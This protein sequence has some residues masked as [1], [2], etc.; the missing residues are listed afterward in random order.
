MQDTKDMMDKIQGRPSREQLENNVKVF[1]NFRTAVR[2]GTFAGAQ[3][4]HIAALL[5]LLDHEHDDNMKKYEAESLAHP[6]WS[7]KKPEPV[8]K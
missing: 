7:G 2:S 5:S 1:H 8:A 4:P 6:E 3:A